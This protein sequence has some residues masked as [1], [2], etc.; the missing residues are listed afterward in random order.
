M[1]VSISPRRMDVDRQ[2]LDAHVAIRR[3]LLHRCRLGKLFRQI[4]HWRHFN[5]GIDDA[6]AVGHGASQG[7]PGRGD[8]GENRLE[9]GIWRGRDGL[10]VGHRGYGGEHKEIAKDESKKA[11]RMIGT[12]NTHGG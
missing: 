3:Q 5:F 2:M 6:R 8:V 7:V 10:S 11:A 4:Q 9:A 1:A 12:L